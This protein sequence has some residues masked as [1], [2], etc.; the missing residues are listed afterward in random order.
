M[1]EVDISTYTANMSELAKVVFEN[2][3][4][5][6][7]PKRGSDYAALAIKVSNA[8]RE[9]K[10][11]RRYPKTYTDEI[12]A[13]DMENYFTNLYDLALYDFNQRGAEGQT[14]VNENGEY[15]SWHDRK[16]LLNGIHPIA[17]TV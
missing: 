3:V 14:T 9:I 2:L 7:E 17:L 11:V 5:D 13:E 8:E 12:I 15:R 1:A 4:I 6:I 16:K 10:R